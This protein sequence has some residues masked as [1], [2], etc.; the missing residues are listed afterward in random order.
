VVFFLQKQT[1]STRQN[2]K[3]CKGNLKRLQFL[4]KMVKNAFENLYL[5]SSYLLYGKRIEILFY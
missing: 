4:N 5:F 3:L 2:A 1:K